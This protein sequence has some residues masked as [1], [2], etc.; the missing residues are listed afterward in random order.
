MLGYFRRR[1]QDVTVINQLCR[2]AETHALADG[3]TGPG[4]E[5]FLLAAVDL[6]DGTARRVFEELAADPAALGPA[7]AR[8]YA[9]PLAA[10]GLREEALAL[11]GGLRQ[12]SSANAIYD[13]APSGQ[14]VMQILTAKRAEGALTGAAVVHAVASIPHGVAARAL[15]AMGLEL[16]VVRQTAEAIARRERASV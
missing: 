15:R 2:S 14:E 6:P 5:H 9:E 1:L 4:A 16:D 12:A 11:V 13:A 10:L 8:Q 7:I 3:Q